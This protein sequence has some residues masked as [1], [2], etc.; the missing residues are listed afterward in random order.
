MERCEIFTVMMTHVMVF[1]VVMPCSDIGYQHFRGSCCL[2][3]TSIHGHSPENQNMK[4][5][6]FQQTWRTAVYNL[7]VKHS[8][9]LDASEIASVKHET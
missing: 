8:K 4:L 2:H 7:T 1:W 9:N 6:Y 5:Q 3:L